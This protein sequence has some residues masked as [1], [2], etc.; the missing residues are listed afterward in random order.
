MKNY[1]GRI[2]AIALLSFVLVG[3]GVS[4]LIKLNSYYTIRKSIIFLSNLTYGAIL[5]FP[6]LGY[7]ILRWFNERWNRRAKRKATEVESMGCL[8]RGI[9]VAALLYCLLMILYLIFRHSI[10]L[11]EVY[12][13][14][15]V[16]ACL[17]MIFLARQERK[18]RTLEESL[19]EEAIAASRYFQDPYFY[20]NFSAPGSNQDS[21]GA[22]SFDKHEKSGNNQRIKEGIG[23]LAFTLAIFFMVYEAVQLFFDVLSYT[24]FYSYPAAIRVL[25]SIL[26][27]CFP[28][29]AYILLLKINQLFYSKSSLANQH[30]QTSRPSK[31]GEMAIGPLHWGILLSGLP[32]A[33]YT[34][35][36]IIQKNKTYGIGSVLTI[37][38]WIYLLVFVRKSKAINSLYDE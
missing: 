31:A 16:S 30:Q 37:V 6:L 20:P 4:L 34:I 22:S 5:L 36:G 14:I 10:R 3:V 13:S 8:I 26:A 29:Y 11:P 32:L 24:Q 2:L 23:T 7:P 21:Q 19:R 28:L 15:L 25:L 38:Y 35:L 18:K 33:T 12:P 17:Y 9:Q 27:F 1:W